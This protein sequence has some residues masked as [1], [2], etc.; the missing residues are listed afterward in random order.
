MT[1]TH[2]A[3]CVFCGSS[4]GS[5]ALHGTTARALG[6]L[7]ARRGFS[8]VFGGG[9]VGL[10]GEVARAVNAEGGKVIGVLPIF[11]RNSEPPLPGTDELIITPDMQQR[12]ARMLSL[13]DAFIALSGGLGTLDEIFEVLSTAHLRVHSKPIA[14]LNLKGHFDP[15][16]SVLKRVVADGFAPASI[17]GLYRVTTNAEE[18]LDY[19]EES[20]RPARSR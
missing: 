11:L 6:T 16:L 8:L 5:D 15:L 14:F 9:N 1:A 2:P 4:P 20:L 12:K 7:I 10:M 13:A 3:I 19:V 18:T 17:D